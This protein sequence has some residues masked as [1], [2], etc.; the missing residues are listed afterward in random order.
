MEK[1]VFV[2]KKNEKKQHLCMFFSYAADSLPAPQK[3]EYILFMFKGF[4][5]HTLIRCT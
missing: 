3:N 4:Y 5:S 1:Y 2:Y